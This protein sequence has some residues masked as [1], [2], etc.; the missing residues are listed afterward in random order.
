MRHRRSIAATLFA[1]GLVLSTVATVAAKGDAVVTLDQALPT[2]PAAG[3]AITVSWTLDMPDGAGGTVPLN[4]EGVFVRFVPFAPMT[5]DPLEVMALQDRLGHYVATVT[6][7]VTG[8]G[9]PVFGLIGEACFAGQTCT[10]SDM[11]FRLAAEPR[12]AAQ[13]PVVPPVVPVTT[14]APVG[15]PAAPAPATVTTTPSVPAPVP[16]TDI[17][18]LPL[19]ALS[20]LVVA[21]LVLA[22]RGRGRGRTAAA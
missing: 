21:G 4:S 3:S 12:T 13:A 22:I 11:Y 14:A 16:A 20:V 17:T 18:L 10:R 9:R 8:L 7:P 2:D 5:G 15:Q 1:V 6:V 19:V